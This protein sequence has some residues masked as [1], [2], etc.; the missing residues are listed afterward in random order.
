MLY[1]RDPAFQECRGTHAWVDNFVPFVAS[2]LGVDVSQL[3][4]ISYRWV[5]EADLDCRDGVPGCADGTLA[6]AEKPFLLHELVHNVMAGLGYPYQPFFGEGIA[7]ALDP[8]SGDRLNYR[9]VV[10]Q[11]DTD[12]LADPRHW[13]TIG[14]RDLHYA[15]A[16]SFVMF[17]LAR[18]GP[19]PFLE[20]TRALDASRDMAVIQKEFR[21]AYGVELDAEAELFMTG[22][23]CTDDSHGPGV[24]DCTTPEIL[25][26]QPSWSFEGEMDCSSDTV[27]GGVGP[28]GDWSSIRS[29]TLEVPT[30]GRYYLQVESDGDLG[31]LLGP[32]DSCP[33]DQRD[34]FLYA[35]DVQSVEL[36]A[37]VHF[38]RIQAPSSKATSFTV[39]LLP[40]P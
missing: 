18:H 24:Y 1:E 33:W 6:W 8:W 21:A 27:A 7:V 31:V 36:E 35:P 5:A 26:D 39:T 25:W 40:P 4:M 2:E 37:G 17:L 30:T 20:F 28:D 10:A 3:D 16:G 15:M 29:V 14:T 13:M 12:R 9:Y 19:A 38:L 23:P 32:C 11:Q 22:A 34:R